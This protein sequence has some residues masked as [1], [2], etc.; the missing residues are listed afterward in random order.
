M[1][2]AFTVMELLVVVAI[3]AII[4][5]IAIP[6]LL[7][8]RNRRI[9]IVGKTFNYNGQRI[10]VVGVRT[11]KTSY[12]YD[13]VILPSRADQQP[14]TAQMPCDEVVAAYKAWSAA[15]VEAP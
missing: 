6:N 12:F 2:R 10:T 4:A 9:E 5:A 7:E 14:V 8:S 15:H 3:I 1:R 13:V 11:E